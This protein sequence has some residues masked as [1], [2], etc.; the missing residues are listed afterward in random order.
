MSPFVPVFLSF[1]PILLSYWLLD[2][3]IDDSCLIPNGLRLIGKT[4]SLYILILV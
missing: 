3:L 2:V 4:T 1:V